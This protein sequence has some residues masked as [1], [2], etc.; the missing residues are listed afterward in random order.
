MDGVV[1]GV[2]LAALVAR[3]QAWAPSIVARIPPDAAAALAAA[4]L[5]DSGDPWHGLVAPGTVRFADAGPATTGDTAVLDAVQAVG[6]GLRD[7]LLGELAPL[8]ADPANTPLPA[9]ASVLPEPP[10]RFA[11]LTS[12]Q[13]GAALAAV[14][15]LAAMRPGSLALL[16]TLVEEVTPQL[17]AA[18]A[19]PSQKFT[20]SGEPDERSILAAHGVAHLGPAVATTLAVLAG[21]VLGT[22][23]P[24]R[25]T[26]AAI[27][28]AAGLA[29]LALRA[30]PEPVGYRAA[31]LARERAEYVPPAQGVHGRVQVSGHRFALTEGSFP[32]GDVDVS[33]TGLAATVPGGVVVRTGTA[34]GWVAVTVCVHDREPPLE[35][36]TV[37]EV[38]EEVVDLSFHADQGFASVLGAGGAAA[39]DLRH[40]TPPRAGDYRVRVQARG[41]DATGAR[42]QESYR[43]T[44]W[45]AAPAPAVVHRR[46]DLLG[47][48]LRGEP[49]P[50]RTQRPEL[51]GFEELFVSYHQMQVTGEWTGAGF[52]LYTTGGRLLHIT[53]PGEVTVMT[54]PHTGTVWVR[55]VA[56]PAAP[57]S[58]D[59]SS[60]DAVEQ[61]T[62]WAPEGRITLCGLMGSPPASDPDLAAAGP[63]LYR[64]E[65]RAR[66]RR[67][68]G[69]QATGDD[70]V[71]AYELLTWPVNEDP[72]H[73]TIREDDLPQPAW[74]PRPAHAARLAM[75]GIL[76]GS[77]ADPFDRNAAPRPI[78]TTCDVAA[79]LPRA[80]VTRTSLI[81]TTPG[82]AMA[83]ALAAL[84]PTHDDVHV[85][86]AGPLQVT[87][88]PR[89]PAA[90]GDASA[91]TWTWSWAWSGGT[92]PDPDDDDHAWSAQLA[93][94]DPMPSVVHLRAHRSP[95]GDTEL[96]VV[97]DGVFAH[98]A[99]PL[100][101]IWEHL[102]TRV[103][104]TLQDPAAGADAHP[105]E[106]LLDRLAQRARQQR[107]E[108][109]RRRDDREKQAF[110]GRPP[111]RRLRDLR[112]AT[113]PIAQ[114]DRN[115]L[116]ALADATPGRQ[117]EVAV[118]TARRACA[119]TQLVDVPWIAAALQAL[120]RGEALLALFHDHQQAW[121]RLLTDPDVPHT[122]VTS[123]SG[124]PNAL[125]QAMAFP[126][127]LALANTDPLA[128]AVDALYAATIA[129]GPDRPHLFEQARQ[130]F[131]DLDTP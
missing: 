84:A 41:R 109:R 40:V 18:F 48:R 82:E 86:P 130:A 77:C 2:L 9:V 70:P 57:S 6:R 25:S 4:V 123:P 127:L 105:W 67:P 19:P 108:E 103:A 89:P 1:D 113:R 56:L 15:V 126:A 116:D 10:T 20:P 51:V 22:H 35:G 73:L 90:P 104:A 101:L 75:H 119:V 131:P 23:D 44:V 88:A 11:V 79:H 32:G 110:G 53:G 62:L 52:G 78:V 72:G 120:D 97:Q 87:L 92:P 98:H 59:H 14:R 26:A 124:A 65:V 66:H 42:E 129:Y 34:D 81:L 61:A 91:P 117:R 121:D 27:G 43:L 68:D 107:V 47:H 71:E 39:E 13:D 3:A 63:G 46:T 24:G 95:A 115:L 12:N 114:L 102:L 36:D 5:A 50:Q 54:G 37:D 8:A 111:T 96:T 125:Q 30:A 55:T 69:E 38:I 17:G 58:Q 49:E 94:P 33:G 100:G 99:I 45:P 64:L 85:L 128:A 76:T 21:P 83:A 60:W 118:W 106:D 122:L 29:L 74:D 28:A 31:V 112:A 80:R 7:H 93:I 16:R